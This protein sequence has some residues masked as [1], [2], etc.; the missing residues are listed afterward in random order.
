[1]ISSLSRTLF[2]SKTRSQFGQPLAKFS[3]KRLDFVHFRP[4]FDR[5]KPKFEKGLKQVLLCL[6][7]SLSM[8]KGYNKTNKSKNTETYTSFEKPKSYFL[9]L[10]I[11]C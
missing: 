1:V 11:Y 10:K 5:N 6:V 9:K 7:S 4:D 8:E 2:K 3:R